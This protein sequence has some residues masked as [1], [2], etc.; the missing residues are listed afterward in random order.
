MSEIISQTKC[1]VDM[2]ATAG[3]SG[4]GSLLLERIKDVKIS[5]ERG[6]EILKAI[7][8]R[9]GAGYRR[10]TG[11]GTLAISEYRTIAPQVDW[12]AVLRDQKVFTWTMQDENSGLREKFLGCT[13]SKI[14][15][16]ADEEGTH[17]DDIEIKFL[18][19]V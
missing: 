19:S 1:F 13:V 16:S 17:M 6:V 7:G 3:G 15:R 8:V 18:R 4:G 5:D 14:D 2:S 10:K 12:R 9:G 11:G